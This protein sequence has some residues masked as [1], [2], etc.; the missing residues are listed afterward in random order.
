MRKIVAILMVTFLL[1][2][3]LAGCIG[4][5]E[6]AGSTTTPTTAADVNSDSNGG[7]EGGE[8]NDKPFAGRKI[9][10]AVSETG[11]MG[12]EQLAIVDMVR[13]KT[14][15]EIEFVI[16]PITAAGEV[17]KLLVMLQAGD[18]LDILYGAT[19]KLKMY[20]S[21]GVL[22]AIDEL[23]AAE[24]YDME[25]IFGASLPVLDDGKTYGLPAFNDVWLTLYN[26]Q[27]FDNK[28]VEY[29]S[30]DG[31]TW[32]KYI[33]LAGRVTDIEN[34]VYG[35]YMLDYDC[36]N[37]MLAFQKGAKPYKADG[38]ANFD[39]PLFKESIEFFYSLGNDRKI[40]PDAIDI[41]AGT[42]PWN[43]FFSQGNMGMFVIGGWATSMMSDMEKY[44]REWTVGI[45]PMP[46]PD[47]F[48]PSTLAVTGCYAIPTTSQNKDVAFE[49]IKCIAEN[50][51]ALGHGRVPAR[52]DLT[53][54]EVLAYIEETMIPTFAFDG[55]TAE[56]I[57]KCWFDPQRQILSEKIVGTADTQL[58]NI[59]KEEGQMYGQKN[60]SIEDT[61]TKIQDRAAQAIQEALLAS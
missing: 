15:I 29:P 52:I 23:A 59:F 53:D 56:D 26:K 44:P 20:Q 35:S 27:L 34:G 57:K 6:P 41:A 18:S 40:Q 48:N 58:N 42:Y 45:A 54:E 36:Y 16:V 43:G 9:T 11:A 61:M 7:E 39:D 4:S 28:G 51:Y 31:F 55:I 1:M 21:A 33:E 5:G 37:Y 2:S 19:P 14:G 10:Y 22:D 32:D 8:V 47:G 46:Y 24:G 60:Q 3:V 50:Q 12:A 25:S 30:M 13:E 17:D 49:A 38:T